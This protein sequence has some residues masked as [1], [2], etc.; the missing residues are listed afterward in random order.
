MIGFMNFEEYLHEVCAWVRDAES[1]DE[2][3][4]NAAATTNAEMAGLADVLG[5]DVDDSHDAMAWKVV[6]IIRK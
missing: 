1:D 4:R 5:I 2:A 3:H 6:R